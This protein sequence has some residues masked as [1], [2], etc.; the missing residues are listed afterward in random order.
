MKTYAY[1]PGCAL[2]TMAASYHLSAVETAHKLGVELRE[3]EDWNCCG[4]TSYSHIDELLAESLCARNLAIA[5]R[6]K[7]DIVAPCSGCYKNLSHSDAHIKADAD[8]A[9][10]LNW[11]LEEDELHYSGTVTVHHLMHMF[12]NEIGLDAVRKQVTHPLKGLRVAPYYGCH[13]VDRDAAHRNGGELHLFEDLLSTL[14]AEVI[15]Y[16]YKMRCCGGSLIATSRR[17][18]VGMLH[19]LLRSA[20]DAK[21]DVIATTCPL[22]QINLELYQGEVNREYETEF[23]IP[24]LY[25]TQLMGLAFGIRPKR[26]GIGRE[27]VSAKQVVACV[28]GPKSATKQP[29]RA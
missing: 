10:H 3:M 9:E 15:S 5:E 27:L 19:D 4:A 20:A 18:A 2:E 8:W 17:A 21:A 23:A 29:A 24:V 12:V 1:Y 26:L 25:F 16:P 7:L 28:R 13:L 14:G 22:C 11:A 6:G